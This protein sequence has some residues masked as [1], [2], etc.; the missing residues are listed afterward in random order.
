M[1]GDGENGQEGEIQMRR[2][3]SCGEG[4]GE[5]ALR[6]LQP[7]AC[8]AW[9]V[10]S[11]SDSC[12]WRVLRAKFDAGANAAAGAEVGAAGAV[13]AR[14]RRERSRVS[15]IVVAIEWYSVVSGRI[16][17]KGVCGKERWD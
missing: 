7:L 17:V 3:W 14:A 1:V 9:T 16:G 10:S 8:A 13:R 11:A 6:K 12:C 5:D 15:C 2:Y 4:R